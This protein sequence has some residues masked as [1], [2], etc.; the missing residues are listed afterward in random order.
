MGQLAESVVLS[1]NDDDNPN[2]IVLKYIEDVVFI[3]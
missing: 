2:S 3:H 1:R